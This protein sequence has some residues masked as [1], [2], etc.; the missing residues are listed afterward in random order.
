[1]LEGYLPFSNN[2]SLDFTLHFKS[3]KDK[4]IISF[5]KGLLE[6]NPKQRLGYKNIN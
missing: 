5:V 3:I 6:E 4:T 2:K 1:M